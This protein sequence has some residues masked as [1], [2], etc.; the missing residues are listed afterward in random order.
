M[1]RKFASLLRI[2]D[3]LKPV[4][5]AVNGPAVGVGVT[6][7]LAM[8]VRIASETA[9]FGLVFARR[10]ITLEGASAWFLPK[11]SSR[12]PVCAILAAED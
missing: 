5:C 8:D 2:F 10:G 12:E 11:V 9:R 1:R 7:Q 6:M 4:I 3:S